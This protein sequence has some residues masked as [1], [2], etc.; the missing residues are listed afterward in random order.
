MSE[1]QTKSFP[2]KGLDCAECART[3]EQGVAAMDG[4]HKAGVNFTLARLTLDYDPQVTGERAVVA[5]VRELGYDVEIPEQEPRGLWAAVRQRQYEVLTGSAGVLIALAFALR[6]VGVPDL[7]SHILSQVS[8]RICDD[9]IQKYSHPVYL[10]ETFVDRNRFQGTC[11]K[12]A[13]WILTG[14]TKG[15]SRNDRNHTIQ[16]PPKDV[17]IYPLTKDFRKRL[18]HDI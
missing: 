3:L 4:V 15:R 13:N 14:Q 18:C 17:Y 10:L 8:R 2:V 16:V 1:T 11:Y 12:A 6:L 5:R 7:A 9:W